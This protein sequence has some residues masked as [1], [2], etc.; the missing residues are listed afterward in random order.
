MD[1]SSLAVADLLKTHG[2]VLAE[3]R[4]R[5]IV[6]SFNN[7]G[8]DLAELLFCRA[9][10]WRRENNSAEGHDAVDAAGLRYQIKGRRLTARNRSRQL[11]AIRKLPEQPFDSLAAVLFD[12]DYSVVRAAIIPFA[13]VKARAKRV[14]HTNSWRF[15]L[16]DDL[17]AIEGVAD[18]TARL[19]AA[20]RSL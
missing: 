19:R 16:R 4:R 6:R 3:L 2:A 5:G 20:V 11:G 8:S 9:F 14:E 15:L 7:P 1:I 17:W 10:G 18:V 12:D 13:V